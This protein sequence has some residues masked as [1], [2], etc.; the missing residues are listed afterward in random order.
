MLV[1]S[2]EREL[3]T[4]TPALVACV[5]PLHNASVRHSGCRAHG[6]DK[7]VVSSRR[8]LQRGDVFEPDNHSHGQYWDRA[9][10]EGE[11]LPS[12]GGGASRGCLVKEDNAVI[13]ED[14]YDLAPLPLLYHGCRVDIERQRDL[15]TV[16]AKYNGFSPAHL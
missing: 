11:G 15:R 12:P 16:F 5:V 4:A 13:R 1:L 7:C 6:D 10:L 14:G 8:Q 9:A 2:K 3:Y